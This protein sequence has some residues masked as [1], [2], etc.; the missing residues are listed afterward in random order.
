MYLRSTLTL[1][2]PV[3]FWIDLSEAPA[4]AAEVAKPA[5]SEWPEKSE[6]RV[7]RSPNELWRENQQPVITVTAALD[8]RDLGSASRELDPGDVEPVEQVLAEPPG[9]D[10]PGQ[11][12]VR[13]L[14]LALFVIGSVLRVGGV[15]ALGRR[16]SGLVAIQEGHELETGG[17]YGV[18]RHPSYLGLLLGFFGWVLVFRSVIGVLII[19][20]LVLPLVVVRM[21]SEEAL[22]ESEFGERYPDYRRRTWR[23]LPFIY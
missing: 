11:L 15:F 13:Y 18:I 19:S 16:F 8:K 23:L 2:W 21:N 4:I 12:A 10:L 3:C 20:L 7:V 6:I 22:L 9:G 5:R 14:G 1:A 17:L